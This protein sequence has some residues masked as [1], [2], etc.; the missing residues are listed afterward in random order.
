MGENAG[1]KL[2]EL[3]GAMRPACYRY[4]L[5]LLV[6]PAAI[7]EGMGTRVIAIRDPAQPPLEGNAMAITVGHAHGRAVDQGPRIPVWVE[8]LVP[9]ASASAGSGYLAVL[10][11]LMKDH[12]G[13][14]MPFFDRHLLVLASPHDGLP[15]EL[16]D[17]KR[18]PAAD[19]P[20][21]ATPMT[22]AMTC[23]SPR[24]MG[25]G[26]IPHATGIKN[27]YLASGE[28]LPGL[29]IEGDLISAWGAARLIAGPQGRRE[30]T[31]REILLEDG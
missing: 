27:V 17:G 13:R 29:G 9:A 30:S 28:N 7:P 5:C 19:E 4:V 22:P 24:M 10:R 26:G 8:C 21:P 3:A 11:A 18:S 14:I 20:V 1:R 12:L 16:G 15:P 2:K 6:R 23:L 25:V 31:R